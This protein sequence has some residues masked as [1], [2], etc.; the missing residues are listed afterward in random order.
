MYEVLN[1]KLFNRL[2]SRKKQSGNGLMAEKLPVIIDNR[3]ENKTLI[4]NCAHENE[5]SRDS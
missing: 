4:I 3:R 5:L 2:V 1:I